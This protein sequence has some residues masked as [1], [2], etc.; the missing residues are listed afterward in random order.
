MVAHTTAKLEV[1][2]ME[3]HHKGWNILL[4]DGSEDAIKLSSEL[5]NG[6][7]VWVLGNESRGLSDRLK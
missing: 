7:K 5:P 6:P 2:L 4:L 1:A 3:C